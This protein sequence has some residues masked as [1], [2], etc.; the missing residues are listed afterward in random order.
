[1]GTKNTKHAEVT[2]TGVV[3]SNFIVEEEQLGFPTDLRQSCRRS[4]KR[5]L[6][7]SMVLRNQVAAS[8]VDV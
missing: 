7:R 2:D 8:A 5:D 1:M 4:L 3:N 6:S